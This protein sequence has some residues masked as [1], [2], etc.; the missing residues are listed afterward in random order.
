MHH[1]LIFRFAKLPQYQTSLPST[2]PFATAH[3]HL[4]EVDSTNSHARRLLQESQPVH[5]MLITADV[6]TA[7]RGQRDR[8]WL[9]ASGRDITCSYILRPTFLGADRQ[10]LLGAAVALALHGAVTEL[11]AG[12]TENISI[13]WPNDILVGREKVAGILIENSL[14][15]RTLDS[16]IVGIGMNVNSTVFPTALRAT[17]LA[18]QKGNDFSLDDV[19]HVM[20]RH[21]GEEYE[22]LCSKIF[23]VQMAHYNRMLFCRGEWIPLVINGASEQVKVLGAQDSGLLNLL[24]SDG[25]VTEHAHHELGWDEVWSVP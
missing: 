12:T 22:R 15:G 8:T 3:Q 19:L 2:L 5:G 18:V 20:D 21:M 24:H 25:R 13:K 9:S 16:A 4:A 6:Q 23:T 10:F 17:S 14:R 1:A 11:L 7:G